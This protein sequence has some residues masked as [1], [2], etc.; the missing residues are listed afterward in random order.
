MLLS[1]CSQYPGSQ[2][3]SISL[4]QSSALIEATGATQEKSEGLKHSPDVPLL[5]RGVKTLTSVPVKL[6]R[7][8]LFGTRELL[9]YAIYCSGRDTAQHL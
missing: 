4:L 6:A 3:S 1:I 2:F 7:I 8:L 9:Y 5:S